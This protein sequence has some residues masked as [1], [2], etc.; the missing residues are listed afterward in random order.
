MAGYYPT[1][2]GDVLKVN[3]VDQVFEAKSILNPSLNKP[4]DV[5]VNAKQAY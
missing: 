5:V 4:M 1:F 2:N 3:Y